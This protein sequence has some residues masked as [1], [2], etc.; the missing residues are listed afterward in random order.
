MHS[1]LLCVNLRIPR[2]R[3]ITFSTSKVRI[4]LRVFRNS[5]LNICKQAG[6]PGRHL[7]PHVCQ[8]IPSKLQFDAADQL[9]TSTLEAQDVG[10]TF[11]SRT[12]GVGTIEHRL[13]RAKRHLRSTLVQTV[14]IGRRLQHVHA[15][16]KGHLRA[17]QLRLAFCQGK[18]G[19]P[20]LHTGVA[21]CRVT[22]SMVWPAPTHAS[23]TL[24][25]HP[26][27]GPGG[28][29]QRHHQCP[30]CPASERLRLRIPA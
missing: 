29:P 17:V 25:P 30:P 7:Q 23:G 12:T 13:I 8:G 2:V 15:V 10:A 20:A 11:Q 14:K 22:P 27:A 26:R 18:P 21:T 24:D 16:L 5:A 9:D 4:A 28:R 19:Q 1:L 6:A 3:A